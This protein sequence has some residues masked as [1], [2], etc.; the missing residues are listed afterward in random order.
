MRISVTRFPGRRALLALAMALSVGL[1]ASAQAEAAGEWEP[2]DS[3]IEAAGPLV[4]GTTYSGTLETSNDRDYFYFYLPQLTQLRFRL[5]NT[6]KADVYI[7]SEIKHQ[8]LDRVETVRDT[9]LNV[10]DGQSKNGAVTLDPGKYYFIVECPGAVGEKYEFLLEPAGVTSTYAPFA[11]ACA[12]A[13]PPVVEAGEAVST[14]KKRRS[15]VRARYKQLQRLWRKRHNG[16]SRKRKRKVH[17]KLTRL[18]K[19]LGRLNGRVDDANGQFDA[20]VAQQEAAC[21]VPQ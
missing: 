16:W 17:R 10:D 8:Y 4:A 11:A 20:A 15:A 12:A 13:Q 9:Y 3:Y 19:K 7:C 5:T 21:S 1:L 6:S 2:N 14:L 18:R